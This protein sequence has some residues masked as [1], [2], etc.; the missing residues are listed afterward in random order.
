MVGDRENRLLTRCFLL[1]LALW[2][3]PLSAAPA[4]ILVN[5]DRPGE[6]Y[7]RRTPVGNQPAGPF[8]A[9]GQRTPAV[10]PLD[11]PNLLYDVEVR[12]RVDL[13]RTFRGTQPKVSAG[14]R[15]NIP[16]VVEPDWSRILLACLGLSGGLALFLGLGVRRAKALKAAVEQA[17]RRA[18]VAESR[19]GDPVRVGPYKVLGRLGQGGNARVYRVEDSYGDVYAL[20]LPERPSPRFLREWQ[21]LRQ[22]HHPGIVRLFDFHEGSETAPAYLVMELAQGES[23][24]ERLARSG[25]LPVPEAAAIAR[26]LAEVLE[27]AH[28]RGVVHRDL[29]PAN[30]LLVDGQVK[31]LDFGLA[32]HELLTTIT[33]PDQMLGTPLYA[34]PEQVDGH[35]ADARSDLFSL[36]VLLYEL[37]TGAPPWQERDPVKLFLAKSQGQPPP[38][39][40]QVNSKVPEPLGRLISE[41]LAA[42]PAAR[43]PSAR[44]VLERLL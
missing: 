23:L 25:R 18:A 22:L 44:A 3:V 27:Y 2:A 32:R 1:A 11:D 17:E 29:T 34:A 37:T 7:L 33:A 38:P 9:T 14:D 26:Q 16:T 39:P 19:S 15:L 30:V 21:V 12:G 6:V 28:A 31:L 4:S 8:Q 43:P 20:K 40:H 41:L 24:Q 36:G 13:F 35:E 42:D 10:I 5:A